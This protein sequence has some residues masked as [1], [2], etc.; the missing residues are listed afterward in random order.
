MSLGNSR[1]GVRPRSKP[2][3]E[4]TQGVQSYADSWGAW[5]CF[6]SSSRVE[7][8]MSLPTSSRHRP[9]GRDRRGL[10]LGCN[11]LK[12]SRS[13][14][15]LPKKATFLINRGVHVS[16]SAN[17]ETSNPKLETASRCAPRSR[18]GKL[19]AGCALLP[20]RLRCSEQW[21]AETAGGP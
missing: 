17:P 6:G 20:P 18:Y 21:L 10:L 13:F 7:A 15:F 11:V 3:R 1:C 16:F 9:I 8:R 12:N 2:R 14:A 19:P 4:R 5:Q